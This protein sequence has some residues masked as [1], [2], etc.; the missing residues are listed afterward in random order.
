MVGYKNF[1]EHQKTDRKCKL[2]R[3]RKMYTVRRLFAKQ[4]YKHNYATTYLK[5]EITRNNY[6]ICMFIIILIIT[7]MEKLNDFTFKE[8]NTYLR[9]LLK[10]K[11]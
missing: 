9:E 11:N 7:I 6:I 4:K 3:N 5:Q 1:K 10:I 8:E 2:L